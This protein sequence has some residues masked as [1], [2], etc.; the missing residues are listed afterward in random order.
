M[1]AL[2]DSI[3]MQG[4]LK[5]KHK[6]M[7]DDI[8]PIDSTCECMVWSP[9]FIDY[10]LDFFICFASSYF[11]VF[12]QVCKNYSR[13]YIHC[14]VTKDA[15]GSQLLSYHNL[16][17]MM[18]VCSTLSIQSQDCWDIFPLSSSWHINLVVYIIVAA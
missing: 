11:G 5:L 2:N 15:M 7:A 6:A 1:I 3:M 4:V 14:L 13:A 8:R 9:Y 12:W 16:F 17:Y 18:K 10:D